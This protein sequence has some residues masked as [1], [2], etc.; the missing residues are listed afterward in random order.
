MCE[1]CWEEEGSPKID[2]PEVRAAAEACRAYDDS[3]SYILHIIIDD[4]NVRD[5]DLDVDWAW[6]LWADQ[7]EEQFFLARAAVDALRPLTERERMSALA[8][9]EGWWTTSQ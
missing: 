9:M 8:L 4:W 7:T 6:S 2:T 1:H 5:I 3:N